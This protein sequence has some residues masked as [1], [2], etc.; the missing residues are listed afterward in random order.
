MT[1]SAIL[2]SSIILFLFCPHTIIFLQI[3]FLKFIKIDV[4]LFTLWVRLWN[5]EPDCLNLNPNL[6]INHLE[7]CLVH[8]TEWAL[9]KCYWCCFLDSIPPFSVQIP[10]YWSTSLSS[11]FM[12]LGIW[13]YLCQSLSENI[14]NSPLVLNNNFLGIEFYRNIFPQH[15]KILFHCLPISVIDEVQSASVCL[16]FRSFFFFFSEKKDPCFSFCSC[17]WWSAVPPQSCVGFS[18]SLESKDSWYSLILKNTVIISEYYSS[19]LSL[20]SFSQSSVIGY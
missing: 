8:S 17:L 10:S 14:F 7:W 13:N 5:P 3:Y 6:I 4:I 20:L 9:N 2:L 18:I 11:Y 15:L 19:Q 16:L 12:D 1:P